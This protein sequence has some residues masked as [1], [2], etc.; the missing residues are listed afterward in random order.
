MHKNNYKNKYIKYKR[1]YLNI[2][3]EHDMT[4]IVDFVDEAER[5]SHIIYGENYALEYSKEGV[6]DPRVSLFFKLVRG[7]KEN[8][9]SSFIDDIMIIYKKTDDAAL[10]MDLFVMTF[11]T[12]D[13]RGGKGER[14]I[15]YYMLL[16]M[17]ELYPHTIHTFISIDSFLW[18]L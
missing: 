12:R 7:L 6:G 3:N 16:K 17:Y 1:K 2:K 8:E 10:I 9:V 11:Q 18:I 14:K 15:F 13:I 5:R 4:Q